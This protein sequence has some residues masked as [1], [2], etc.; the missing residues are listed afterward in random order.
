MQRS[1]S[2]V[3]KGR[4]LRPVRLGLVGLVLAVFAT[5]YLHAAAAQ[6]KKQAPPAPAPAPAAEPAQPA[7]A[8]VP[9]TP[10][11]PDP[12]GRSTP[13]GCVFG[14][15]R[16]AE[17]QDYA[18]A[19]KYL[20]TDK[21]E[22]EAE[23]LAAQ[24]KSLMDFNTGSTDLR[25]LSQSPDGSLD[26]QLRVTREKVTTVSTPS[27]SVDIL[28]DRVQRTGEQPIWLFAR[29]TLNRVPEAAASVEHHELVHY[30][31][32]WM[33]RV[34][35][36]SFPL[37]RWVLGIASLLGVLVLAEL[38]TRFLLW[39]L[40]R[41][42]R[43]RMTPGVEAATLKLRPPMFGVMMAFVQDIGS[44]Y[45]LTALGR[46]NW[47]RGALLTGLVSGAWLLVRLTDIFTSFV[48]NRLRAQMQIERVTFVGLA[49]RLF[50]ILV[51][52][53]LL[54][55]LLTQ[56][57]VNVSALI[58]GLGIG[59]VA[60][61]LAAQKTLSD[62]FGGISIV[63]RGAVRVGDTCIIAG[64]LGIIE[65]IG[66]SSVRMRTLDRTVVSIPNTKV[67]E[68]ELENFTMRDRF[69]IHPVFTLRFD[70]P[71]SVVQKVL[72]QIVA[73]LNGHPDVDSSSS[74]ARI[75][76]LTSAG[77]QI[78]VFA[79]YRKPGADYAAFLGEQEQIFLE[80]MRI[81]EEQG[82]SMAAPLGLLQ[83]DKEKD[84]P[85]AAASSK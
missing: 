67:A 51:G 34:E 58:T 59:G 39:L 85:S 13:Q 33:S 48:S 42:L 40:K 19:A 70:T 50:K 8:P 5:A 55:I 16:A 76:Q 52:I 25:S 63:M 53:I 60:L 54:I 45:S 2:Y 78:E 23:H 41:I 73:V 1:P 47:E 18:K 17:V 10:P 56:A 75:I 84:K 43:S 21:P 9:V 61:A 12:L 28:L 46:H 37:W 24:L 81:V 66:I 74:R 79:Y 49:A 77:P 82:T 26:D 72:E 31:P 7:S 64:K 57:G 15:L 27:G 71:Y 30:F 35:F 32:A 62:L 14:F 83:L 6:K 4:W 80:I 29:G 68:A 20:D 3:N 44:S 69:W 65:E 38:L 11:P 36:L 22:Q